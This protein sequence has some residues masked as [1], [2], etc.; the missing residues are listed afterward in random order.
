MLFKKIVSDLSFSPAMM[1]QLSMLANQVKKVEFT[2]RIGLLLIITTIFIQSATLLFPPEPMNS[3]PYNEMVKRGYYDINQQDCSDQN[4][5]AC[6][7]DLS[8]SSTA[9]NLSQGNSN[10]A[11]SIAEAGDHISYTL[12]FTNNSDQAIQ[13]EPKINIADIIEYSDITQSN[14]GKIDTPSMTLSW[15]KTTIE[16]KS[17]QSRTFT[18]SLLSKLPTTSRGKYY[19]TSHDCKISSYFGSNININVNCPIVKKIENLYLNLPILKS[20]NLVVISLIALILIAYQ[21][22]Q[23][24][25]IKKEIQIIRRNANAGTI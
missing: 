22:L 6:I 2:R 11:A 4:D 21:Y 23:A 14:G 17:T 10:A 7:K 25:Q 15:E 19:Q 20:L 3:L 24:R 16:P 12:N 18:I 13:A 5:F 1:G 8:K 9:I